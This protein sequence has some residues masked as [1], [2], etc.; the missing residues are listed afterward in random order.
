MSLIICS[1]CGKEFSD[2]ANACPVCGCPTEY[3]LEAKKDKEKV[4]IHQYTILNKQFNI[5][6][7]LDRYLQIR[8]DVDQ[9]RC[10]FNRLIRE[11]YAEYKNIDDLYKK[12][13]DLISSSLAQ[14]LEYSIHTLTKYGIY[15]YDE[16]RFMKKYAD[17][18][19]VERVF[20]SLTDQYLQILNLD[21]EIEAYHQSIRNDRKNYWSGGGFSV[22]G[23]IEGQIKAQ[24]MNA[25]NTVIHALQDSSAR[26]K[27]KSI[28]S[29]K[30]A[31]L[32][33]DSYG[34][35]LDAM[36]DIF[37][38]F[39]NAI[40][41]ELV[42]GGK[43]GEY[44]FNTSK[45][46]S[47]LNNIDNVPED[48]KIEAVV[49]AFL[50]DPTFY[51][52]IQFILRMY[53]KQLKGV[54]LYSKDYG[55]LDRFIEEEKANLEVDCLKEIS[56]IYEEKD[57]AE[58]STLKEILNLCFLL[59]EYEINADNLIKE[60]ISLRLQNHFDEK[61]AKEIKEF[62][63]SKNID[64]LPKHLLDDVLKIMNERASQ[65]QELL[66]LS[67]IVQK[68]C[69]E[70]KT[71]FWDDD[72]YLASKQN[73]CT[74]SNYDAYINGLEISKNTE[75]Y[76]LYGSFTFDQYKDIK[77][78]FAI[79]DCGLYASDGLSTNFCNWKDFA[80]IP[81]SDSRDGIILGNE[82]ITV[83]NHNTIY[84]LLI[85]IRNAIQDYYEEERKRKL[86]DDEKEKEKANENRAIIVQNVCK[87]YAEQRHWPIH[88]FGFNKDLR[89]SSDYAEYQKWTD[90]SSYAKIYYLYTNG[91]LSI[92]EFRCAIISNEGLD[93]IGSSDSL[94]INWEEFSN[95]DI[96]VN[97]NAIIVKANEKKEICL[98]NDKQN[99][100]YI[101]QLLMEIKSELQKNNCMIL[102]QNSGKANDFVE[103]FD[104]NEID[105]II[106]Q[107]DKN[108]CFCS[109]CG[110]E[111]KQGDIFCRYCGTKRKLISQPQKTNI[112]RKNIELKF[113][114]ILQRLSREKMTELLRMRLPQFAKYNSYYFEENMPLQSINTAINYYGNKILLKD[115][116]AFY[117]TTVFGSGKNGYIFTNDAV[118]AK[119]LMEKPFCIKY[120]EIENIDFKNLDGKNEIKIFIKIKSN[121]KVLVIN[122]NS[123]DKVAFR[124]F[125]LDVLGKSK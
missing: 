43:I 14:L 40:T 74:I 97:N 66:K 49:D 47:I 59:T 94:H 37:D 119:E 93:M 51:P 82:L 91:K 77:Y 7:N 10:T 75:I 84:K 41:T 48:H 118:Y 92:A 103:K 86:T 20:S 89:Y 90:L 44:N 76:A 62:I 4:Y 32:F 36:N 79:T 53:P 1:E 85:A 101:A 98:S 52:I 35:V 63:Y 27:D 102:N 30:K 72:V 42:N 78:A 58:N 104:S 16:A 3:S 80:T 100:C 81:F 38:I 120:N 65:N 117:D 110:K 6:E 121:N 5:D 105:S 23:A 19:D 2:K 39:V 56:R 113:C 125:L 88:Q 106:K 28:V 54:F 34:M 12:L 18:I 26:N 24:L 83:Y 107:Q 111:M 87:K 123:L 25:G 9:K 67:P 46:I 99:V 57:I 17:V 50:S 122:D 29:V 15:E 21:N 68:I 70:W 71:G 8:L 112:E 13:P 69:Y 116:I 114:S 33:K 60:A 95:A 45:S 108:I 96:S 124:L 64:S 11:R 61:D 31:K 55:F 115:V 109:N 22:G 73:L